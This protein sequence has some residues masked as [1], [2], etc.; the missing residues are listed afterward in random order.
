M[1]ALVET[2][3]YVRETPWHGLGTK[4]DE[5]PTSAEAIK[6]AGLDWNVVCEPIYTADNIEIPNM[7]ANIR[8]TDRSVLGVVSDRYKIVQNKEAFEF[9]DSLI[10]EEVRYE[11][12]GSLKNGK[13]VWMLAKMPSTTI[14]GDE[15]DRYFLFSNSHDGTSAVRCCLTNIRV[16]CKNTLNLA[17]REAK[18]SWRYTHA[19][20]LA[21]KIVDAKNTLI[22]ANEYN[23]AFA[24]EAER[25]ANEKLTKA[26]TE[27]LIDK[28]FAIP[29]DA[30]ARKVT[31]AE[32]KREQFMRA[33]NEDDIN[34]FRYTKWGLINSLSDYSYHSS[35]LRVTDS[36]EDKRMSTLIIPDK[37]LDEMYALVAA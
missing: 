17:L 5:A 30:S 19:G 15:F 13:V 27:R 6:L 34:N 9:T 35:P 31:N 23:K 12:A 28:M 18:R 2:M 26:E 16:V 14:V 21:S 20:D 4:V 25:L 1:S 8:D 3:F 36:Y 32:Y 24:K 10:N 7:K 29:K 37:K 33:F 11:T 22:Y